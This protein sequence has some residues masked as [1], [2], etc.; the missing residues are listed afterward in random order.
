[1]RQTEAI[2]TEYTDIYHIYPPLSPKVDTD[3]ESARNGLYTHRARY[4][5]SLARYHIS[6]AQTVNKSNHFLRRRWKIT[7]IQVFT[8][9]R[10]TFFLHVYLVFMHRFQC[11]ILY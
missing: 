9:N 6:L 1:M 8:Q 5:I 11:F 3:P 7:L 4:H 2:R 10:K